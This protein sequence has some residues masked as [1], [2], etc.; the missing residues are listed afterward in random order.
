MNKYIDS[1]A[2][3]SAD[4]TNRFR[5][6]RYWDYDKPPMLFVML[7]PSTANALEDDATIRKCVGFAKRDD[8]GGI[9]V[10]N[11]FPFRSRDPKALKKVVESDE[12]KNYN[13]EIIR[14]VAISVEH[15]G[16]RVVCAWGADKAVD[17]QR[18]YEVIR[19]LQYKAEVVCYALGFASGGQPR[20]PLMLS[21][22]TEFVEMPWVPF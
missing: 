22:E 21:Y 12:V 7:N 2:V 6:W 16:G 1:N 4:E 10:V 18:A 14:S 15:K 5:L 19:T 17:E 8:A 9:E 3:L 11:L 20:H 13:L